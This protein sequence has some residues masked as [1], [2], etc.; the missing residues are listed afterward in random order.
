[1]H[2]KK[3]NLGTGPQ[4]FPLNPRGFHLSGMVL[5]GGVAVTSNAVGHSGNILYILMFG[6]RFEK[7]IEDEPIQSFL[8][9]GIST[10]LSGMF[11]RVDPYNINPVPVCISTM[12]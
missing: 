4:W 5:I 7:K 1:M 12:E 3:L 9:S 6:K 2:L 8:L 10:C 11:P